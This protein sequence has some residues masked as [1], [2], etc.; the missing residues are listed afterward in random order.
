MFTSTDISEI[1][2]VSILRFLMWVYIHYQTVVRDRMKRGTGTQSLTL[3][4]NF[5]SETSVDLNKLMSVTP[6]VLY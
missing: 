5:V 1:K 3:E 6:K 2:S 4:G